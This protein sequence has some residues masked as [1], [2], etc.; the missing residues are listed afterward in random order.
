VTNRAS[1]HENV[2]KNTIYQI[3]NRFWDQLKYK[4]KA[5]NSFTVF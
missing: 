3:E 5:M 2:L 1:N 4:T